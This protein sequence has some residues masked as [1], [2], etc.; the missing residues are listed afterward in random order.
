MAKMFRLG[1]IRVHKISDISVLFGIT[2]MSNSSARLVRMD[3]YYW[4]E[5]LFNRIYRDIV[6]P[7]MPGS[8]KKDKCSDIRIYPSLRT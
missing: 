1:D 5:F 7:E 8:K 3:D 2:G 4:C 6:R